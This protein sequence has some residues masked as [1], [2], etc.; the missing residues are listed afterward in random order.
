MYQC[1]KKFH[2][3]ENFIPWVRFLYCD[4]ILVVKKNGYLSKKIQIDRSLCQGCS[5]SANLFTLCVEIFAIK[6]NENKNIK[7][8]NFKKVELKISQ[9]ADD[10]TL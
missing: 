4:P 9:Y 5:L 3:W 8:F 6:I 7:G 1:L 10:S 2:F